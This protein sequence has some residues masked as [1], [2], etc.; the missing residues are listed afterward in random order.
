M[1]DR[2]T[3]KQIQFD[4]C[5]VIT[6]A[7]AGKSKCLALTDAMLNPPLKVTFIFYER[8]INQLNLL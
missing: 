4:F 2:A 6:A 3:D 8:Q 7:L 5:T 1:M